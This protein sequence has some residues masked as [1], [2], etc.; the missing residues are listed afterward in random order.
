LIERTSWIGLVLLAIAL[1]CTVGEAR[2]EGP[3]PED[4]VTEEGRP[5]APPGMTP[6]E[7]EARASEA[8]AQARL[9]YEAAEVAEA[10]DLASRIVA[11]YPATASAVPARWLG[12]RAAFTLGRYEEARELALAYARVAPDPER[13]EEAR[14]LARLAA[15]GREAPAAAVVGAMLPRTGSQVL[16]QY[17]DWVL[18]GIE[19]AVREAER[20][21]GRSVRLVVADDGGGTRTAA[22]VTELERAGA[23]AIVGPLLPQQTADASRARRDPNLVL[24]S[25][26]ITDGSPEAPHTYS[27]AAGDVRGAQELGRYAAQMGLDRAAILHAWGG[28]HDARA[29][30]FAVEYEALGGR[31]VATVPYSVGTTTFATHMQQILRAVG[32]SAGG[33]PFAVFVTA[34]ERDVPQIAPQI[35]FYGLD[36]A[37][38]Q[39][40]GDQ[41]WASASVRRL[42]ANRDMEG[43]ITVSPFAAGE[44][45]GL[46]DPEFVALFESTYRRSLTNQMPALGHDAA[47]VILEALPN[48]MLTPDA[49]ARRFQ[50]LAGIRGATG[51]FSVRAS[52]LIRTPYLV[53]IRDGR[54]EQATHPWE[55]QADPAGADAL[56]GAEDGRRP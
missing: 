23:V 18:E 25:P 27:V 32:G 19:L 21:Q 16:V 24:V 8:L 49:T 37:G 10:W 46:A 31:V 7:A 43:V 2:P 11:S 17:G 35:S 26:T 9:S 48:R 34:P 29:R 45:D 6:A 53:V 40:M 51:I 20:R 22:A 28:D 5:A 36:N 1:G 15:D 41:A 56:P 50:L 42:V 33:R 52:R 3:G 54:L 4:A 55:Y 13:A 14:E 47:R 30:A 38:A 39:V 44:A 12:A